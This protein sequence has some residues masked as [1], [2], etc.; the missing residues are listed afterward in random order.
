[1]WH[2]DTSFVP[3]LEILTTKYA[4]NCDLIIPRMG[5]FIKLELFSSPKG[6]EFDQKIAKKKRKKRKIKC[7]NHACIPSPLSPNIDTYINGDILCIQPL[8]FE[9]ENRTVC[10]GN[11]I[12][13]SFKENKTVL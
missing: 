6:Q 4:L 7:Y 1:M 10:G 13:Q 3:A 8:S 11:K 2:L 9:T 12:F 5:Y